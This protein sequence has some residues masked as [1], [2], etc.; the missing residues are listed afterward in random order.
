MFKTYLQ[1][2]KP[3][4]IVGN[5][6]TAGA[7]FLLA[8]Q[9]HI[10]WFVLFATLIGTALI[11]GAGCVANNY[12]DRGID[13]KMGRTKSRALATGTIPATHA[14]TFAAVLGTAGFIVLTLF[15]NALTV[16]IG[17][18]GLFFY[19]VMYSIWKRRSVYGTIVGSVAGAAPITAGYTAA[20][21]TFDMGAFLVFV[22]LTAW[23]LPHFYAIAMFR[24]KDYRAA[25]LP[26]WPVKKG[27]RAT[28]LQILWSIGIFTLAVVLLTAWGIA[29][30]SY[31]VVMLVMCALWLWKGVRHFHQPNDTQWGRAMF[32]FS[33]LVIL[34]FS[35]MIAV[36][37]W[38]P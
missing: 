26:V 4:I 38:L 7:G 35:F 21:G 13:A 22:V 14:L 12:I 34:V 20:S 3:G 8:A 16:A 1:L 17:A 9:G 15:T 30:F 29:G 33:L 24:L 27:T 25:G 37:A 10:D 11:I 36:D 5:V 2:T 18:I 31:L 6:I 19:V 32:G 28:K 23:Q